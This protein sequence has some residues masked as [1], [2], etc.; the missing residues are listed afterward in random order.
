METS[1]KVKF[2][3]VIGFIFTFFILGLVIEYKFGII[4]DIQNDRNEKIWYKPLPEFPSSFNNKAGLS[5]NKFLD[6]PLNED[7]KLFWRESLRNR[8]LNEINGESMVNWLASPSSP[9]VAPWLAFRC[10]TPPRSPMP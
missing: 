10:A 2:R 6:L 4:K 3:F 7:E 9:A 1:Y 8:I 5:S